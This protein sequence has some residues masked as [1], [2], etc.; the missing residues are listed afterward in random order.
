MDIAQEIYLLR[1]RGMVS[2][3]HWRMWMN[4]QMVLIAQS[5]SFHEV[6]QRATDQGVLSPEFVEAFAPVFQNNRITDPAAA[7]RPIPVATVVGSEVAAGVE[8]AA[9]NAMPLNGK[10]VEANGAANDLVKLTSIG[11]ADGPANGVENGVLNGV[12]KLLAG[13]APV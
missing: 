8:A 12:V 9:A 1:S 11:A 2:D 5:P 13:P 3:E 6:F 10:A 4:D 7:P